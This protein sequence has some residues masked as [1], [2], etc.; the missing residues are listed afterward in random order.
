MYGMLDCNSL[1]TAGGSDFRLNRPIQMQQMAPGPVHVIT[2]LWYK[3]KAEL[4]PRCDPV[5]WFCLGPSNQKSRTWHLWK[6]WKWT[7]LSFPGVHP[8]RDHGGGREGLSV[9]GKA[10]RRCCRTKRRQPTERENTTAQPAAGAQKQLRLWGRGCCVVLCGF[11]V[12]LIVKVENVD[13]FAHPLYILFGLLH[14]GETAVSEWFGVFIT[15][16]QVV[17]CVKV[18][19]YSQ[20]LSIFFWNF[21]VQVETFH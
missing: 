3:P 16:L 7:W 10:C 4:T 8:H 21:K 14:V 1:W 9:S 18:I 20:F 2:S 6:K 13:L 17:S 19:G 15:K 12:H 5:V 11:Q